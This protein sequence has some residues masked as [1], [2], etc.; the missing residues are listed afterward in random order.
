MADAVHPYTSFAHAYAHSLISSSGIADDEH[1][2][3]TV[4][5]AVVSRCSHRS[6]A[7]SPESPSDHVRYFPVAFVM[8][9]DDDTMDTTANTQAKISFLLFDLFDT[10]K[11]RADDDLKRCDL[12]IRILG[13]PAGQRE[14]VFEREQDQLTLRIGTPDRVLS[15]HRCDDLPVHEA[16]AFEGKPF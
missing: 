12:V 9:R 8:R 10:L 15:V 4:E 1:D 3:Y 14:A 13:Y 6:L 11:D 2:G 7:M 5:F 16:M